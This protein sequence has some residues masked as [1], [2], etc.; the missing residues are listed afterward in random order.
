MNNDNQNRNQNEQ[1]DSVDKIKHDAQSLVGRMMN[2][3]KNFSPA[4]MLSGMFGGKKSDEKID[5]PHSPEQQKK[6][7]IDNDLL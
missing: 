4:S 1:G 3:V 6:D 2:M 5:V 7:N